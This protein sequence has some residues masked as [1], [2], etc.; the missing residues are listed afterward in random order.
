MTHNLTYNES[1]LIARIANSDDRAFA[2]LVKHYWQGIYVHVFTYLKR[3]E[4]SEEVTQ[5]IFMD[6]WNQREQL[7][8]IRNFPGF[9]FKIARYTTIDA[10]RKKLEALDQYTDVEEGI[11]EEFYLP[12]L[13]LDLKEANKELKSAIDQLPARRKEIFIMSRIDGKTQ[14][15]IASELNISINTVNAQI[16][17]ALQFLRAKLSSGPNWIIIQILICEIVRP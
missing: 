3:A 7:P 1:D 10:L 14:A 17:S 16:V 13:Q 11:R 4:R 12:H 8:E 9:L 2:E 6:I 15:E 5:D